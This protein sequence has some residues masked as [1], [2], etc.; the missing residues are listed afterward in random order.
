MNSE[1][2]RRAA[3]LARRIGQ[4]VRTT[5]QALGWTQLELSGR[6]GVSQSV[7]SRLERGSAEASIGVL[8]ALTMPM[9]LELNAR[10]FPANGVTVRDERQLNLVRYIVERASPLWQTRIEARVTPD[11][12]DSRGIDLVLGSSLEILAIK[13]ERDLA[14]FQA[15]LRRNLAKRDMLATHESRPVRFI[16]A[17][18]DTRRLRGIIRDNE[19]LIARTLPVSSR[20]IWASIRA[21]RSVGSNGLLWLPAGV[22]STRARRS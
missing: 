10:I 17:L 20:R 9:G 22:G 3:W 7:V 4:E 5:R 11:P 21:G 12:S 6:S 16:L 1:A 13:V 19:A 14:D 15:Q 2:Q 8:C 18:P